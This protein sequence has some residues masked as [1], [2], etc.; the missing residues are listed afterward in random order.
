MTHLFGIKNL[1]ILATICTLSACPFE[2]YG[3]SVESQSNPVVAG[4]ITVAS[5]AVDRSGWLELPTYQ[6]DGTD[7]AAPNNYSNVQV[8]N[9]ASNLYMRFLMGSS[10]AYAYRHNVL[11]DV[12]QNRRTG[13]I[14]T[15]SGH[16][17]MGVDYPIQGGGIFRFAATTQ[18]GWLWEYVDRVQ[19]NTSSATDIAIGVPSAAF[20]N[21]DAFDFALWANN[22]D[23]G[24]DEDYYPNSSYLQG[25][26]FFTYVVGESAGPIGIDEL[27]SAIRSGLTDDK[28]DL[29]DDG[30]VNGNDHA[31]WVK[32]VTKTHYGDANL[33]LAVDSSDFIQ[34][35]QAGQ[36]EDAIAGNSLWS[37][38][39]WNGDLDFTSDD[40]ILALQDVGSFGAVASVS[41]VP[42]PSGL[43]LLLMGGIGLLRTRRQ[44]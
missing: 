25:G 5:G 1:W 16:L 32:N 2:A 8:A 23:L 44:R 34:V 39:D 11:I 36:Y 41:A 26:S 7:R 43:L 40:L 14:G 17:A 38:G 12:D 24:K 31:Y 13:F 18:T 9:D 29:N 19:S 10:D 42:E 22:F 6:A 35:F 3:A 28:F 37:T 20:G 27:S 4:T 30:T 15:G 21:D 33:D